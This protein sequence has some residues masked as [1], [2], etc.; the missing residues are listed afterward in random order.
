MDKMSSNSCAKKARPTS[1]KDKLYMRLPDGSM[2]CAKA[3]PRPDYPCIS[4]SLVDA[5]GSEDELLSF[6]EWNQERNSGKELC[7]CAYSEGEDEPAYYESY[8]KNEDGYHAEEHE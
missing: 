5:S 8:R 1:Q 4:I 3:E 6:V 2:L 7:L